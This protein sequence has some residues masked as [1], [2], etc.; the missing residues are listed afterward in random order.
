M[1]I[2]EFY[3]SVINGDITAESVAKAQ[4][5]LNGLDQRNEKRKSADSKEKRETAAR[6]QA[7]M[8]YLDTNPRFSEDIAEG[9]NLSVGQ[10]R[11]ALSFLVTNGF[12]TKTAVKMTG[13]S[14]KMAYSLHVEE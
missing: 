3:L 11:S 2:R 13:H 6:R 9:V 4:E 5:L 12:A 1:T 7:V 10:V 8:A 14:P